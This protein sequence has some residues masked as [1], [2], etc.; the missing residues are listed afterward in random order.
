MDVW[1]INEKLKTLTSDYQSL[2]ARLK[3][4]ENYLSEL[5]RK[6][7]KDEVVQSKK[8]KPSGVRSTRRTTKKS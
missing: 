4:V 7:V 3:H 5:S 2:E 6:K 1:T 8:S